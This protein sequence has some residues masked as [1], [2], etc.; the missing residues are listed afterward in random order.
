MGS[1]VWSNL[2]TRSTGDGSGQARN[3]YRFLANIPNLRLTVDHRFSK[4]LTQIRV[5]RSS[6]IGSGTSQ[7]MTKTDKTLDGNWLRANATS[8]MMV[9]H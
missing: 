1:P 5:F 8:G 2:E 6:F 9:G 3:G 7:I 4:R